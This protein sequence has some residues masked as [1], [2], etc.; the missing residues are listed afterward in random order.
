M[1][2]KVDINGLKRKHESDYYYKSFKTRTHLFTMLFGILSCCDSMT[3]ICII[4]PG[5]RTT[6]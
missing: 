2:G 6:G 5:I 3:E 1:A 4:L